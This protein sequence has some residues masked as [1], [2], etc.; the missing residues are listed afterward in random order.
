MNYLAKVLKMELE[1]TDALLE[2]VQ[3]KKK[4]GQFGDRLRRNR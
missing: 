3:E 4:R 1:E 2:K